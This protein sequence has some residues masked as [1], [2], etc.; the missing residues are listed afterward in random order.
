MHLLDFIHTNLIR[1]FK[2]KI[3]QKLFHFLVFAKM[4]YFCLIFKQQQVRL[5]NSL[6]DSLCCVKTQ[7]EPPKLYLTSQNSLFKSVKKKWENISCENNQ[8]L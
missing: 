1:I 8:I 3:V 2:F 5:R 6:D 4:L 7:L